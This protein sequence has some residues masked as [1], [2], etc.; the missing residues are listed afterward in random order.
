VRSVFDPIDLD[1]LS[2]WGIVALRLPGELPVHDARYGKKTG[3]RRDCS[4]HSTRRW[5]PGSSLSAGFEATLAASE[6]HD[7]RMARFSPID[8]V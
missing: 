3:C 5:E 8:M 2:F 4:C 6:A 1:E 7:A